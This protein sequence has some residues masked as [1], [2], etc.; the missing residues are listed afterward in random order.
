MLYNGRE[1]HIEAEGG[2]GWQESIFED[3]IQ[4]Y[5]WIR[6]RREPTYGE[7][8]YLRNRYG[9]LGD[10]RLAAL[11]TALTSIETGEMVPFYIQRYGFY[12]GHTPYRADPV[13]IAH[14]FGLMTIEQIDAALDLDDWGQT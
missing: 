13:A 2:K 11:A 6:I 14:L 8:Q 1:I 9:H 3:E 7:K 4:G 5:W 12:E 10:E